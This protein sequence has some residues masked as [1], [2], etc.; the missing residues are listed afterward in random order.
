ML[1]VVAAA[2]P[3][4]AL[5]SRVTLC[6]GA[7]CDEAD[8]RFEGAGSGFGFQSAMGDVNDD[9]FSD[10]VVGSPDEASAYVFFGSLDTPTGSSASVLLTADEADVLLT[11]A[12]GSEFGFSVAIGPNGSLAIGAPAAQT[13]GAGAAYVIPDGTFGADH[14]DCDG[15][16]T[17]E[18]AIG[19]VDGV[20]S[21]TGTSG[22]QMGYSVAVGPVVLVAAEGIPSASDDVVLGARNA[23]VGGDEGVGRVYVVPEGVSDL[24]DAAVREVTG[25]AAN[26]G[27][28]EF[29]AL[30]DFMES[31]MEGVVPL[32]LEMAIS[33]I[34]VTH[35]FCDDDPSVSCDDD[36]DCSS[37]GGICNVNPGQVYVL[38][39]PAAD[40]SLDQDGTSGVSCMQGEE[41]ADFFGFSLAGGNYSNNQGDELAIGAPYADR[42]SPDLT[43]SGTVYLYAR[44]NI[45]SAGSACDAADGATKRIDGRKNWD[46]LGFGVATTDMDPT[47][48]ERDLLM[49]ARWHD[50]DLVL[51][52]IDE[53]AVYV[54]TDAGTDFANWPIH[55]DC[56]ANCASVNPAG[57]ESMLFG[58]DY[59]T[60]LFSSDEVGFALSS[61][62]FNGDGFGDIAASSL[63]HRRVYLVSLENT[64]NPVTPP[65]DG[66]VVDG[67]RNV[68]DDDDDGDGIATRTVSST[69]RRSRTRSFRTATSAWS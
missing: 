43:N 19:D 20:I 47:D 4:F 5:E 38:A 25:S 15:A 34:G 40:V 29:I 2:T 57:V 23:T 36:A 52:E 65:E 41:D 39:Y 63:T 69:T 46:Q 21:F 16:G 33:G 55:V 1:G 17:S 60:S 7:G 62:D 18:C 44:A 31:P 53:G 13:G 12:A 58:G 14:V 6:E 64:D 67:L 50:R 51:N 10:V 3:A 42:A 27:L 54:L 49:S 30:G 37:V 24:G 35:D 45:P 48:G 11:G 22:D 26:E 8:V 66:Q 61:G 9:G 28:G 32:T 68:R 59:D 56:N